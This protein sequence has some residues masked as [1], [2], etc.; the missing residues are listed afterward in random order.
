[1]F[2]ALLTIVIDWIDARLREAAAAGAAPPSLAPL[3]HVWEKIAASA[4]ET[5]A[6]NLD[7]RPLVLSI[8]SDLSAAV[9]AARG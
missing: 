5:Q 6:L 3:A 8:F 7:R 2:E 9:S 4:R 1:M